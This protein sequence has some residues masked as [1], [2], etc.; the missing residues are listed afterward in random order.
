MQL[1]TPSE[2][3]ALDEAVMPGDDSPPADSAAQLWRTALVQLQQQ[4]TR[5]NYETYL[6]DTAGARFSDG[7]LV[8]T[9]PSDFVTE[10]LSRRFRTPVMQTL[11]QIAG[12]PV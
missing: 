8:I 1:L 4:V 7:Q 3:P 9:A 6:R 2:R 12:R 5:P 10:W 11:A